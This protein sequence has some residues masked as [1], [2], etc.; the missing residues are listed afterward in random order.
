MGGWVDGRMGCTFMWHTVDAIST[1]T[2]T[3]LHANKR[4]M[5]HVLVHVRTAFKPKGKRLAAQ[6]IHCAAHVPATNIH[7][8][9][10]ACVLACMQSCGHRVAHLFHCRQQHLDK[11]T[12]LL[13]V[14]RL[15]G[16]VLNVWRHRQPDMR[17]RIQRHGGAAH[18]R[19]AQLRPAVPGRPDGPQ[20]GGLDGQAGK[21]GGTHIAR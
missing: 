16:D 15:R 4:N 19:P 3:G 2:T 5:A 12:K 17:P 6:P 11:D 9:K 8:C 20:N 18:A 7:A 13:E 1:Q 21:E 14:A 10:H